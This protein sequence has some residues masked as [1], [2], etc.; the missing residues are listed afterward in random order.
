MTHRTI[1]AL[2][3]LFVALP[4]GV[5]CQGSEPEASGVVVVDPEG[6]RSFAAL[7]AVLVNDT[8]GRQRCAFDP[9][10]AEQRCEIAAG[11]EHLSSVT[12]YASLAD[13]VE[14][15][16]HVGKV[17]GLGETY[18]E[19]GEKRRVSYRYDELGR[20]L[21]RV[22]EALDGTSVTWYADYDAVGRPRRA[23]TEHEGADECNA[24]VAQIEYSDLERTVVERS[25]P[26]DAAR[27]GF[28]ERTRLERYDAA[29]NR[30]SV[31][32][33]DGGGMERLFATHRAESTTRVCL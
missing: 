12:E 29:G 26:R 22:E 5:G 1:P 23:T 25:R 27:C 13:F 10:R 33:A 31:E 2:L 15:G 11:G 8:P 30:V 17:T 28:A 16:R 21:R 32:A 20:L 9:A 6:C 24:W 14:A 18:E 7:G 4:L 19:A 3:A